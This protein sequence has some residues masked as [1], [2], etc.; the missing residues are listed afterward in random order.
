MATVQ[1]PDGALVELPD[2]P[3]DDLKERIRQKVDS[4]RQQQPPA[5]AAGPEVRAQQP[6]SGYVGRGEF[7]PEAGAESA[8]IVAQRTP[9]R[10]VIENA[11]RAGGDLAVGIPESIAGFPGQMYRLARANQ[12]GGPLSV[13]LELLS[14]AAPMAE[15][16]VKDVQSPLGSRESFRGIA[17]L[18]ML[19]LPGLE[20][21]RDI[22]GGIAKPPV[23][24]RD[25]FN[26][27]FEQPESPVPLSDAAT[28]EVADAS[29]ITG[30]EGLGVRE[31][32]GGV[33]EE[34]SLRQ[35]GEI[36]TTLPLEEG[37]PVT[38]SGGGEGRTSELPAVD[39]KIASSAWKLPN[40]E[41][42]SSGPLHGNPPVE[43][44]EPGF[45]TTNGRYLNREDAGE[46]ATGLRQELRGEDFFQELDVVPSLAEHPIASPETV[47]A[48]EPKAS[49][50][51][52]EAAAPAEKPTTYFKGDKAEYTGNVHELH[53]GT[54]YEVTMLEGADAGKT[55]VVTNPPPEAPIT[56][57]KIEIPE[58]AKATVNF[59][60]PTGEL[61]R[62]EMEAPELRE[63]VGKLT[64]EKSSYQALL[65][66]LGR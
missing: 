38:P 44:A 54:F 8:P 10:D 33:G 55:K 58:D 47:A 62:Q 21:A 23:Q 43:N 14:Q 41:I 46:L 1:M 52:P 15:Q 49:D 7:A 29:K 28:K 13:A 31:Q 42:V 9:E 16:T 18:G 6:R 27:L 57:A 19:A 36:A 5:T 45:L 63:H 51:L 24:L 61:V 22:R 35:P 2:D 66:C 17:N 56:P 30:T 32:G 11:I 4:L 48:T 12:Q 65:D 25:A 39:E 60:T 53:G 26:P 59:R 64:K 40:G 3:D 20:I 50:A 34:T 37:Q